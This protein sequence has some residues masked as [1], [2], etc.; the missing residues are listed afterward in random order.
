MGS[1]QRRNVLPKRPFAPTEPCDALTEPGAG[2]EFLPPATS[3]GLPVMSRNRTSPDETDSER[4]Q[5][6][7]AHV[8][9]SR[10]SMDRTAAVGL[11]TMNLLAFRRVF[12][13]VEESQYGFHTSRW[14]FSTPFS[15]KM[16]PNHSCDLCMYANA[17]CLCCNQTFPVGL[18]P[19]PPILPVCAVVAGGACTHP[20]LHVS[21]R[22]SP[23]PC[24]S[25]SGAA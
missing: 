4:E 20:M 13:T 2:R 1:A 15:G 17:K 16:V 14:T 5:G 22:A 19:P 25:S 6:G 10:T 8:Q 24:S 11:Q 12:R 23:M 7:R 3:G 21:A 9:G 18:L